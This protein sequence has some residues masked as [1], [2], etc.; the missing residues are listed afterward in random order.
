M[1]TDDDRLVFVFFQQEEPD[2]ETGESPWTVFTP[3]SPLEAWP[4]LMINKQD[5]AYLKFCHQCN[6][7]LKCLV[8]DDYGCLFC[9]GVHYKNIKTLMEDMKELNT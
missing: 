5:M 8:I 9:Y 4:T 3:F 1:S 7:R 2:D 6:A